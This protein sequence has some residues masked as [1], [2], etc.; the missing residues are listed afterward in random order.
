MNF[1]RRGEL[2]AAIAVAAH[3]AGGGH[4][5]QGAK[6]LAAGLDE[7]IGERR[8]DADRALHARGDEGVDRRHIARRE[9]HEAIDGARPTGDD[10]FGCVHEPCSALL[11][12]TMVAG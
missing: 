10:E 3:Q 7:V 11:P 5:E 2:D 1:H 9:R 4:G 12:G 8:D 6:A